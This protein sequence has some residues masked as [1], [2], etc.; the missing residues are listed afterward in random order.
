MDSEGETVDAGDE[1]SNI[2]LIHRENDDVFLSQDLDDLY[3]LIV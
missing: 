1:I 2:V 3:P